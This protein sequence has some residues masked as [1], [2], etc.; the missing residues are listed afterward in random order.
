MSEFEGQVSRRS[1]LSKAGAAAVA[2]VAAGALLKGR[3][4]EA[5]TAENIYPGTVFAHAVDVTAHPET[6]PIAVRG[7]TDDISRPAT[8]GHNH[9]SGLGVLGIGGTGVK[10]QGKTDV[11]GESSTIGHAAV[12]GKHSNAGFDAIGVKGDT[13]DGVGVKGIGKNG[14]IGESPTLG[15]AAVYGQHVGSSGYG[16]VGDGTGGSAGVVGR[17]RT[18]NGVEGRDS[19]Y[20][21]KFAGSRAQLML[22]PKSTAGKPTGA[23]SKGEIYMDS[24]ANLFVCTVGGNP[25]TWRKVTTT[26]V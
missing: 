13:V 2:A 5:H 24:A 12:V 25:A 20:G 19:R 26:A 16:V 11:L 15:H 17:N 9:G 3:E 1:L 22:E 6:N 8:Y 7:I 10:G 23:H 18:G 14:V 4:V 21:G